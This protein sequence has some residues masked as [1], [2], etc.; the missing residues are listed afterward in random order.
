MKAINLEEMSLKELSNEE[1]V[2]IQGGILLGF[3]IGLAIGLAAAYLG[4]R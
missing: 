3:L 4:T 2:K 1:I